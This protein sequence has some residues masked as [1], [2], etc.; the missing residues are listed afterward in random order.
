MYVQLYVYIQL[1]AEDSFC[2]VT[3]REKT[4]GPVFSSHTRATLEK[5]SFGV[6]PPIDSWNASTY[7]YVY[8]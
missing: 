2:S 8:M 7:M 3:K 6:L 5:P 1:H 4:N